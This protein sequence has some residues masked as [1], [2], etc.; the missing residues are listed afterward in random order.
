MAFH[1]ATTLKPPSAA[2][3][4]SDAKR[5]ADDNYAK[6][7][8]QLTGPPGV[9]KTYLM[10]SVAKLLGVPFVK[11]DATKFTETGIVGEAVEALV[12]DLVS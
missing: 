3:S 1:A 12:R 6:R 10:K 5:R 2:P 4:T 9:G 11:G 7:T 8:L